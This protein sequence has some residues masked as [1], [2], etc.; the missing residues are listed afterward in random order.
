MEYI[1]DPLFYALAVPAVLIAGI[2]KAGIGGGL[3]VV[4]V[5]LMTLAISPVQAAAILL[6]ILCLMDLFGLYAYR[7][8]WDRRNI[9]LMLPGALTGIIVGALAFR[10][11]SDDVVRLIVGTVAL[12]F[13]LYRAVSD[14]VLRRVSVQ[15]RTA[16]PRGMFWAGLAG[17]TSFVAHAGAPPI[18]VYLLP[19]RLDK[20][21]YVGTM[22]LFFAA[23]NYAKLLP[24]GLLG[25]LSASNLGTA[26][27]L[28]PVIPLGIWLGLRLHRMLNE[29]LFYRV[30]FA[31]L[32]LT[33]LRLVWKGLEGMIGG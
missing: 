3:G 31:I 17:F 30:V 22:T 6:P 29:T 26:L 19:Q 7:G 14:I 27:L 16:G 32:T 8:A 20:T 10:Y 33:G 21:V 1:A 15:A 2:S 9:A 11:L 5:P 24:Y 4:A 18:Q 23:V 25:Q 13:V 12:A 28:A